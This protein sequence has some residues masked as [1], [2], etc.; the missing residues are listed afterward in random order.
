MSSHIY[1]LFINL[2]VFFSVLGFS[3]YPVKKSLIE[4]KNKLFYM[5]EAD[6]VVDDLITK[7]KN[8]RTF[9]ADSKFDEIYKEEQNTSGLFSCKIESR[10][11]CLNLNALPKAFVLNTFKHSM[12]QEGL[13]LFSTREKTL[14]N[15]EIITALFS[16]PFDNC[17]TSYG[18][19]NSKLK[20]CSP[21]EKKYCYDLP[22]LN[23]N[24]A[25]DDLLKTLLFLPQFHVKNPEEKFKN[26]ISLRAKKEIKNNELFN[27]LELSPDSFIFNILGCESFF[28]KIE[29]NTKNKNNHYKFVYIIAKKINKNRIKTDLVT[30]YDFCVIE[31]QCFKEKYEKELYE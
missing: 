25:S 10:S 11:S 12:T 21:D 20:E 29:L 5:N 16:P 26:L 9:P 7:L 15:E 19:F 24:F 4:N 30:R 17:F 13:L 31:K 23:V 3:I 28:W 18:Y 2:I 27:L 22:L 6:R 1:I 8:D 14:F